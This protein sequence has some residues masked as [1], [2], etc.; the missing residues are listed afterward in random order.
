VG[1][2]AATAG[3]ARF[4]YGDAN[5]DM[6]GVPRSTSGSVLVEPRSHRDHPSV[7]DAVE[8]ADMQDPKRVGEYV[9]PMMQ[10]WSEGEVGAW[11]AWCC[12]TVLGT[13]TALPPTHPSPPHV[14]SAPGAL[15]LY[16]ASLRTPCS[17]PPSPLSCPRSQGVLQGESGVEGVRGG[18]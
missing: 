4:L 10:H 15:V 8:M 5:P 9:G 13:R 7:P 12:G 6:I 11:H 2:G 3:G 16:A 1:V 14:G 18:G 17:H